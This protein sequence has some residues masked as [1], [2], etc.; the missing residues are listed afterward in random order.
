MKMHKV[1]GIFI[2]ILLTLI[3]LPLIASTINHRNQLRKEAKEYIP[4]GSMVEVN[5]KKMHVYSQ[6]EGE[7]SLIFM[8]GHG[9]SNPTLDFMP[10]WMRLV[11][12]YRIAVVE[13][14]GY[15]WS[16]TS[17]S[18]RDID[19]MLEETRKALELSGEKGPYVLFPHSMSGLEALYWA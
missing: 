1:F 4:P 10:L 2:I 14:S 19:T 15:G 13:K 12:E 3:A 8:S 9:T 16:E 17:N 18:P 6:G 11:D 7:L 5:G